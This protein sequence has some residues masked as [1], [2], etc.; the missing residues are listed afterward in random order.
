MSKLLA[1]PATIDL[2]L[3]VP[4]FEDRTTEPS[5]RYRDV[6]ASVMLLVSKLTSPVRWR[7]Q[8]LSRIHSMVRS[9]LEASL[10]LS[11]DSDF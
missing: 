11:S 4:C 10:L 6:D 1:T 9:V 7:P 2:R 8:P 5:G 3:T